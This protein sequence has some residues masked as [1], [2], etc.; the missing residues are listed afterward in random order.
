MIISYA[1]WPVPWS[2][3]NRGRLDYVNLFSTNPKPGFS[4]W[5]DNI[6]WMLR[7]IANNNKA[8]TD[9]L[10]T[11]IDIVSPPQKKFAYLFDMATFLG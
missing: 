9:L 3:A 4:P 7:N 8:S 1:T 2:Q 10:N 11:E 6:W 5:Y